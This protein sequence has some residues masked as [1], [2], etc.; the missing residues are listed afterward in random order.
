M[1]ALPPDG[2][3]PIRVYR[4]DTQIMVDWCAFDWQRAVEPFFDQAVDRELMHPFNALFR[5][6]TSLDTLV[7][8]QSS[9]YIPP[10]SGFV[11]HMSRCG[12]TL[13]T[14]ML[15]MAPHTRVAVEPGS[16]SMLLRLTADRS[17]EE[18]VA[19]LRALLSA[20]GRASSAD[21]P[22]RYFFKFDAWD[23]CDLPLIRRAFPDTPWMFL[24]RD[25]LEVLV[26]QMALPSGTLLSRFDVG[27]RLGLDPATA[28]GMS[29]EELCAR[30]LGMC[31][32]VALENLDEHA[33]L[34]D[35]CQLHNQLFDLLARAFDITWTPEDMRHA[36]RATRFHAKQPTELFTDDTDRKRRMATEAM[37]AAVERWTRGPY[38]ELVAAHRNRD[39]YKLE[40]AT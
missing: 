2:W 34:V 17:D 6:Q 31:C 13:V 26:S 7:A 35:Y 10:P 3:M 24:Y 16:I 27:A 40:Q 18:R 38:D 28:F 32:R 9:A 4:Q 25:P 22:P 20:F 5:A 8:R 33:V 37:S 36:R 14:R 30:L 23:T 19:L 21:A 15:Q 29:P 11:F 12:S 1:S 39:S